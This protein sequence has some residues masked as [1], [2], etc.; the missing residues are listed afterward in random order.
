MS[1]KQVILII[2]SGNKIPESYLGTVKSRSNST[3]HFKGLFLNEIADLNG[4]SITSDQL[5]TLAGGVGIHKDMILN[6]D[7]K[8]VIITPLFDNQVPDKNQN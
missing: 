6:V 7:D 1:D 5:K 3:I 8:T 2:R 4:G